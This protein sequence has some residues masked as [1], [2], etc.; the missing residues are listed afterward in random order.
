MSN[1]N[2]DQG[3]LNYLGAVGGISANM[4]SSRSGSSSGDSNSWFKAMAQAWGNTLDAQANKITQLS[5]AIGTGGDQPSNMV[6][7][8]AESLAMG[9]KSQNAATSINSVAEGLKAVARK[10]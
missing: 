5:D 6:Q 3:V 1:I 9:F 10:E 4:S 7:L 8:T 2:N